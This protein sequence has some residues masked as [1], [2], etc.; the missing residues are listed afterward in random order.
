MIHLIVHLVEEVKLG[1]PIHYRWMYPMERFFVRLKALVKNRAHL[2]GS[3]GEGYRLEE[4]MTFCSRFLEGN[5]RFTRPSRNPEPSDKTKE[6]SLFD[7]ASEPIGKATNVNQFDSQLLIQSHHYVL[8]HCDELEEFR[9]EFVDGQKSN[10]CGSTN[11]SPSFIDKLINEHFA[12]WLEKKIILGDGGGIS[13]RVRA[14][15]AKPSRCGVRYSGY[16]INGFRF[17]TMSHEAARLTQN[18]DIIELSYGVYKVVLFKCDWYDVHH[19]AG[20]R[21]DDFG[22]TLVNFSRRI[23][24]GEKLEHDPF[25]FSSQVE[26][27]FY[28]EDPKAKGWNI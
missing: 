14:L 11:L 8:W 4:C 15:A 22:F 5:T 19:R 3:I 26:Q 16:I 10:L 20:L 17:H 25:V 21:K 2:E 27:V 13:K 24:I 23:H 7:N 18:S 6:M 9:Q 1:G 28:V 12:D